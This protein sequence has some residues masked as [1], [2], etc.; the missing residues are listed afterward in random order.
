MKTGVVRQQGKANS[1]RHVIKP[2]ITMGKRS[3]SCWG[4]NRNQCKTLPYGVISP[5]R[6]QS[7]GIGVPVAIRTVPVEQDLI[8]SCCSVQRKLTRL[9]RKSL[10]EM[11]ELAVGRC[12]VNIQV[13]R[14]MGRALMM[15]PIRKGNNHSSFPRLR[16]FWDVGLSV[17][18]PGRSQTN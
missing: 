16:G 11:Q 18:N 14:N 7:W 3:L 1:K 13:P 10:A 2:A 6:R 17:L 8:P 12:L 15:F 9:W 4:N 5:K